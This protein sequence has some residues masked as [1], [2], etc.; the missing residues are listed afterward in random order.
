M[1]TSSLLNPDADGLLRRTE[2]RAAG[3]DAGEIDRLLRSGVLI[4]VR[5]GVYRLAGERSSPSSPEADHALRARAAAPELSAGTVFARTTAAALLGLPLWG[6][7]L[8]RLHV[9]R[10]R[11]SGGRV[12][13]GMHV[14]CARLPIGDVLDLGGVRVTTPA[15]T[16]VDLARS[17]PPEQALVAVD[18]ALHK[19]VVRARTAVPDPG[20]VTP[21]EIG[22]IVARLPSARGAPAARRVLGLADPLSESPGESR[23]RFRMHLA[24]LPA[25]VTQWPVPGTRYR[26]DFAWPDHGL[27]GEFDG[28]VKYGRALLPGMDVGE[29]LWREKRR[30]DRIR[31]AGWTAAGCGRRSAP[32]GPTAWSRACDDDWR[33]EFAPR[34][35]GSH[36]LRPVRTG[37]KG[38]GQSL[39]IT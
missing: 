28:R 26:V 12:R 37:T 34:R 11:S 20:A 30:E 19:A 27:L 15:R 1:D 29:I 39:K 17:V 7:P 8:D 21:G 25:P 33:G 36:P 10:D 13:R 31:A 38:C 24:G 16:V 23:S 14:H 35:P 4:L 2:L 5:R 3:F 9:I 18:G 6:L 32:Q 22:A